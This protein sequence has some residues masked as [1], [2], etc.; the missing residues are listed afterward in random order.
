MPH[1]STKGQRMMILKGEGGEGK[2][3]DRSCVGAAVWLQYE[4][5]QHRK[6]SPTTGLPAP[7]WSTF[8][9]LWM[10]I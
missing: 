6:K 2:I 4:G 8:V 9:F 10:T 7:I 5:R 1:S 3:A